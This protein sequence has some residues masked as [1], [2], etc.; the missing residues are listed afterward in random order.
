MTARPQLDERDP[1]PPPDWHEASS[2]GIRRI[3]IDATRAA[4]TAARDARTTENRN[5]TEESQA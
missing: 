3:A 5:E 4:V 1:L 2:P